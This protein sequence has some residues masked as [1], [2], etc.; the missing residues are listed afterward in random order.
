MII[1]LKFQKEKKRKENPPKKMEVSIT[2]LKKIIQSFR[3]IE[4]P[5]TCWYCLV[6]EFM[7]DLYL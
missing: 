7:T 6:S 1:F 5:S 4:N 2:I 3:E